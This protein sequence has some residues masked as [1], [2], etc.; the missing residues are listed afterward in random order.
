MKK[1]YFISLW[2]YHNLKRQKFIHHINW[3]RGKACALC[4]FAHVDCERAS[5]CN[6]TSEKS[7]ILKMHKGVTKQMERLYCVK[8]AKTKRNWCIY[9][10]VNILPWIGE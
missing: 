7:D 8:E 6:L 9:L 10:H 2:Y 3:K 5:T 1:K 4:I